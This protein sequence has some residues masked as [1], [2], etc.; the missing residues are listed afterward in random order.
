MDFN[1]VVGCK[2]TSMR[3][4]YIKGVLQEVLFAKR[5]GKKLSFK[6]LGFYTNFFKKELSRTL[7]FSFD[8]RKK[9]ALTEKWG[10]FF[11]VFMY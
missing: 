8:E 11:F 5:K 10:G 4:A 1:L 6:E 7:L 2:E 9:K 3:I